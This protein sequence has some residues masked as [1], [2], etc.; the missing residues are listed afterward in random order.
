MVLFQ[1]LSDLHLEFD[2]RFDIHKAGEILLL[3]GDIGNPWTNAYK[4]FLKKASSLF[5]HVFVVAGNHEYYTSSIH[6]VDAHI[7]TLCAE[8]GNVFFL[9]QKAVDIDDNVRVIGATLW[10]NIDDDQR[11][12]VACFLADYRCIKDWTI[13]RNNNMHTKHLAF[14]KAEIERAKADYKKLVVLTH[15]APSF[16]NTSSPMHSGGILSSAFA[17]CLDDLFGD[18]I[19]AW[20]YGHTH[21]SNKQVRKGMVLISNQRGYHGEY[22]KFNKQL[23][24]EV[25]ATESTTCL[26]VSPEHDKSNNTT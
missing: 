12:D 15:H 2:S 16:V 6:K 3:A 11:S 24:F 19:V 23:T 13:E 26:P 8:L 22:T 10:S 14:I 7:D 18:P 17:T 25:Q 9:Q 20:A 5:D 21:F 4:G 1:L